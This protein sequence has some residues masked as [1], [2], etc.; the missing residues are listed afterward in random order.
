LDDLRPVSVGAVLDGGFE[1]LRHRFAP[2]MALTACLFVPVWLLHLTLAIVAPPEVDGTLLSG[3]FWSPLSSGSSS[4]LAVVASGLQLVALSVL[5]LCVGHMAAALARGEET[6]LAELGSLALRRF[7]VAALIVPLTSAV[8]LVTACLGGV[9]WVLGDAVVFLTSVAAGAERLGPWRAFQRSWQL[10]RPSFGRALV[11]SFG[12]L[13]I[14][15]VIRLSLS[16]GPAALALSLD[17][18]SPLV[19]FL[20]AASTAVLLV[21]E[22]LTACIAARAY[23]DLRC[24]REGWDL[25]MRQDRLEATTVRTAT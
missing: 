14:S 15:L 19:E 4:P 16:F 5:G 3:Q 25:A 13:C 1:L 7:W 18:T 17:P 6:T 24:R 11:I 10:T 23:L 2:L 20:G 9:G 21:T 12:G 22:P 8:H